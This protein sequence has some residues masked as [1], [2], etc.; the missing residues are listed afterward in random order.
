MTTR[1]WSTICKRWSPV[2]L[3]CT[4][5]KREID[6][7]NETSLRFYL[8]NE[9]LPRLKICHR[10]SFLM[11][12]F[13]CWKIIKLSKTRDF[14]KKWSSF[15]PD[16]TCRE[17]I[18]ARA[19]VKR[20]KTKYK[21][22]KQANTKTHTMREAVQLLGNTS[23]SGHQLQHKKKKIN[24]QLWKGYKGK[25]CGITICHERESSAR[26]TCRPYG[27]DGRGVIAADCVEH[28]PV[29][30]LYCFCQ[31]TT[32]ILRILGSLL[33]V[34]HS[35]VAAVFFLFSLFYFIGHRLLW[36]GFRCFL[37]KDRLSKRSAVQVVVHLLRSVP[38]SL[39]RRVI[40][41]RPE[42][43]ATTI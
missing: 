11:W 39:R 20:Q 30:L 8:I 25:L 10:R 6:L 18:N 9:L 42:I 14:S 15:S 24:R 1:L 19:I 3:I 34:R 28:T 13:G 23:F 33:H 4:V 40:F 35:N 32:H 12:S 27:R 5:Q 16:I 38:F 41:L 29:D 7:E 21:E 26:N 31:K 22:I 2:I 43:V 17:E 37:L 36:L